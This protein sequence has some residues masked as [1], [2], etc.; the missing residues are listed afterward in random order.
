M[1][2]RPRARGRG[3]VV[4]RRRRQRVYIIRAQTVPRVP[5]QFS[6]SVSSRRLHKSVLSANRLL[7]RVRDF[8]YCTL[9]PKCCNTARRPVIAAVRVRRF[10]C[11]VCSS[12]APSV[13]DSAFAIRRKHIHR[14]YH[15]PSFPRPDDGRLR[16]RSYTLSKTYLVIM[17]VI[18]FKPTDAAT[19]VEQQRSAAQIT[20]EHLLLGRVLA[21]NRVKK[22]K[23]LSKPPTIMY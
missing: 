2:E 14:P 12:V 18:N 5:V 22:K 17:T 9:V 3:T 7:L 19:V 15:L 20:A 23:N 13:R 16:C 10:S 6:L 21:G 11:S 8:R 4:T 1:R